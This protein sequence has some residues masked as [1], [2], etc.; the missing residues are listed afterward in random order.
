M[1]EWKPYKKFRKALYG[2]L[3]EQF[4]FQVWCLK[5][6]LTLRGKPCFPFGL[7]FWSEILSFSVFQKERR[8]PEWKPLKGWFHVLGSQSPVLLSKTSITPWYKKWTRQGSFVKKSHCCIEKYFWTLFYISSFRTMTVRLVH[9]MR[10][11]LEIMILETASR[12]LV[13]GKWGTCNK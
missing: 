8:G 12:L 6:I 11:H 9:L 1:K 4:N 13:N 10:V 5:F 3:K 7:P 2:C